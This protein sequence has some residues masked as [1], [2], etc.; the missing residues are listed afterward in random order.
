MQTRR[1]ALLWP[2]K[3]GRASTGLPRP[4]SRPTCALGL[5]A[6]RL[7]HPVLRMGDQEVPGPCILHLAGRP[8]GQISP[9]SA[10]RGALGSR[11]G[12]HLLSRVALGV[13]G[14]LSRARHF[15]S[16]CHTLQQRKA[17]D[18]ERAPQAAWEEGRR[19]CLPRS[20][21]VPRRSHAGCKTGCSRSPHLT[22]PPG[23]QDPACRR[24]LPCTAPESQDSP[25]GRSNPLPTAC[26]ECS[27]REPPN[28]RDTQLREQHSTAGGRQADPGIQASASALE[29]D[30]ARAV[31]PLARWASL[32]TPKARTELHG[33]VCTGC[34]RGA[35]RVQHNQQE[36]C[37]V[38]REGDAR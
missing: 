22:L 38:L 13:G 25:R 2:E 33:W 29:R 4:L 16:R 11:L 8:T 34:A 37:P 23:A 1:Q 10:P 18:Y 7:A 28:P 20:P 26:N 27:P 30:R 31:W 35:G 9:K 6:A 24:R 14:F 3:P 19:V 36:K 21:R 17:E 12:S 32:L 15:K 5:D